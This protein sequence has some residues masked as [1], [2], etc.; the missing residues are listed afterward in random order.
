MMDMERAILA[1]CIEDPNPVNTMVYH[2]WLLDHG[3][4]LDAQ[5]IGNSKPVNQVADLVNKIMLSVVADY[6]KQ[7]IRFTT[8]TGEVYKLYHKQ[9][10]CESVTIDDICGDLNDLVGSVILMAEEQ[11]NRGDEGDYGNTSTWTFYKFSTARGHVTIRWYGE[12]NGYYSESV[13]FTIVT[14]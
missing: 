8:V 3:R 2:D 7:E 14:D 10:C 11:S 1:S 6:E 5:A 4:V 12:S 13:D 9:N